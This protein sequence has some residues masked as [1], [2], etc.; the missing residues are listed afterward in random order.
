VESVIKDKGKVNIRPQTG[1]I[2]LR[3]NIVKE[4]ET[5]ITVRTRSVIGG[6]KKKEKKT[7][8][9][10]I[11]ERRNTKGRNGDVE[12]SKKP[13]HLLSEMSDK[14]LHSYTAY[15]KFPWFFSVLALVVFNP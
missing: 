9:R 11:L 13:R 1:K 5:A 8:H 2:V 6:G 7:E 14:N 15:H 10:L 3:E 4:S 12:Q